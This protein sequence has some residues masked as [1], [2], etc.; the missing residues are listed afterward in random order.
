MK[1]IRS[2]PLPAFLVLGPLAIAACGDGSPAEES[3]ALRV[4]VDSADGVER[5][6]NE[7]TPPR[8]HAEQV[9]RIGALEGGGPEVFG[10]VR[11]IVSDADGNVYVADGQSAEIRVF[12]REGRHLRTLGGSG[13]GPGEFRNLVGL[14]WAGG[15]LAAVDPGNARIQL[16]SPGGE[17]LGTW[18]TTGATGSFT[19][20]R[21]LRSGTGE[22]WARD[23]RRSEEG[24]ETI[25]VRHT[26]DGPA[27]TLAAP[28]RPEGVA[29]GIDCRGPDYISFFQF[30][31]AP[32]LVT[33][34]AAGGQRLVSWTDGYR[35]AFLDSG[36]D[37]VRTVSWTR[38]PPPISDAE[39]D[40]ETADFRE[41]RAARPSAQCE[42]SAPRRPPQR[43]TLRHLMADDEGRIWAESATRDGFVWDVLDASG[44]WLAELA[45]PPRQAAVP[46]YVRD[47][48]LYQ[49]EADDFDVQYVT[50]YRVVRPS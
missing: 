30:P 46:P 25:Y 7:G 31:S 20:F 44:A 5:V 34:M 50:A 48:I 43:S 12:D 28:A 37:T 23:I 15:S 27:D 16:L 26:A 39:W 33:G 22:F 13:E 29:S 17:A 18:P 32:T 40:E 11:S 24:L 21:P 14:A 41:F 6:R 4:F 42:P 35:A 47:G 1:V 38:E 45:L 49:V 2:V 19:V 8:W 9:I 10:Q 36:G 3:E